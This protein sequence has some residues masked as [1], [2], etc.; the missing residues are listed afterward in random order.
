LVNV[1]RRRGSLPQRL[2]RYAARGT[3]VSVPPPLLVDRVFIERALLI[4]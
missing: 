3:Q 1:A 4:D 2:A